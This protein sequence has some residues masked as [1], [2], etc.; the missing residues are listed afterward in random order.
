[1]K[2]TSFTAGN[3]SAT[4]ERTKL[5]ATGLTDALAAGTAVGTVL[6]SVADKLDLQHKI[7]QI[8]DKT[9]EWTKYIEKRNKAIPNNLGF[10]LVYALGFYATGHLIN[11]LTKSGKQN[12]S[13][14]VG[15]DSL[16]LAIPSALASAT[17]TQAFT[18]KF[19]LRSLVK[20]TAKKTTEF[21]QT[22][23]SKNKQILINSVNG[24]SVAYLAYCAIEYIGLKTKQNQEQLKSSNS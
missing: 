22:V 8:K 21:L 20:Q 18:D 10:G 5:P 24:L 17:I 2:L 4:Q 7:S 15:E 23:S 19:E 9:P 6:I 12:N 3:P 14:V 1:M 11:S 13:N 16:K